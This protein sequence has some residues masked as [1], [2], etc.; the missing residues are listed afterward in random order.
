[1]HGVVCGVL[2]S[3][4]VLIYGANSK[5]GAH[6]HTARSAYAFA[7]GTLRCQCCVAVAIHIIANTE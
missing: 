4:L 1:M 3:T 2:D 7:S 6:M 5:V